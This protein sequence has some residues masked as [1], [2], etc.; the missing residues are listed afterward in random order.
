MNAIGV[1]QFKTESVETKA[2]AQGIGELET[3]K[4]MSKQNHHCPLF[5][6]PYRSSC[7]FTNLKI[8]KLK[9]LIFYSVT[10]CTC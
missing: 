6:M 4:E 10:V 8:K 9:S 2:D 1:D 5:T 3:A 7:L